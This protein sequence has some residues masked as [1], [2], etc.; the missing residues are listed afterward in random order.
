MGA[1][2]PGPGPSG[3]GGLLGRI[4]NWFDRRKITG[5]TAGA[6]AVI[7]TGLALSNGGLP[8]GDC[9]DQP[10]QHVYAPK[11]LEIVERCADVTGTVMAYRKEHDGDYHVS[12]AMDEPGWVNDVN[13]ARQHGY[14]VVEFV[15][16]L[17]RPK[18]KVGM[19]LKMVGTRVYDQQHKPKVAAHGWVEL[20]PVFAYEVLSDGPAKPL[21]NVPKLAPPTEDEG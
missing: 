1:F 5:V 19:R 13:L 12:M 15:P 20:H 10:L 14:T 4:V 17:P 6:V 7:G 9:Q 21:R 11:R 2:K 18:F 3:V 8:D 16:L